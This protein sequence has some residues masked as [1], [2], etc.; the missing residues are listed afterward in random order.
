MA[1]VAALDAT[2]AARF[3]NRERGEVVVVPVVL[4]GLQPERVDAHL[5]LESAHRHYAE[6]LGL[7]AREERRAVGARGHADFD[8]DVADLVLGPP[9]GALLVHGDALA[10]DRLL[11]LVEGHLHRGALL[12][13]GNQLLL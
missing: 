9:V 10:D 4:F 3:P 1:D 13:G 12:L 2:H 8:R 11:E 6:R 7:S 5:L